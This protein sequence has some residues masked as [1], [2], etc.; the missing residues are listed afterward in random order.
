LPGV[1]KGPGL[2][3]ESGNLTT[4]FSNRD[5]PIDL[6]ACVGQTTASSGGLESTVCSVCATDL[7]C[8]LYPGTVCDLTVATGGTCIVPTCTVDTQCTTPLLSVCSNPGLYNS[9]CVGCG[10]EDHCGRFP[11]TPWCNPTSQACEEGCY[12]DGNCYGGFRCLLED[13]TCREC[14][15]GYDCF[16]KDPTR[17]ICNNGSTFFGAGSAWTCNMCS[18][19]E[20]CLGAN[21]GPLLFEACHMEFADVDNSDPVQFIGRCVQD[22]YR[23]GFQIYAVIAATIALFFVIILII[24]VPV[25]FFMGKSD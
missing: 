25:L 8:A 14:I 23:K 6:P 1:C 22:T 13:N 9:V 24:A 18:K 16:N 7:D 19:S 11:T 4:C 21:G 20:E 5:C 12:K 2:E 15:S 17:P 10:G 3:A